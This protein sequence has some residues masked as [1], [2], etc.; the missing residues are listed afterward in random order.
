MKNT[1]RFR[2]YTPRPGFTLIELLVVIAIIALLIGILLPALSAARES[3]RNVVCKSSLRTMGQLNLIYANSNN[4]TYATPVTVGARYTGRV[5]DPEQGGLVSGSDVLEGNSSAVTPTSTQDWISPIMGDSVNLSTNRAERTRQIFNEFGCASARVFNDIIYDGSSPSD[6]DEFEALIID[7][8]RQVSY[9]MPTGFAHLSRDAEAY[10]QGF[11]EEVPGQIPLPAAVNGMMSHPSS[12]QQPMGFRHKISRVGTSPSSKVMVSDA[13][14]YWDGTVLD[15]DPATNPRWYG[16][17]TAS[18]PQYDG[19][20]SMGRNPGGLREGDDT[21]L[22]LTFRH[23]GEINTAR[24]DGSVGQLNQTE[25][26]T[27]PRPWWPTG[28]RWNE[29]SPTPESELFMED[30][31]DGRID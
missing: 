17:F 16:S 25:T 7:G 14:R 27:D 22:Q 6:F 21:N 28:T 29:Q 2:T 24:F 8:I 3:A 20:R 23:G 4:E 1:H 13:T 12:P 9:L 5:V 10:I 30:D 26:W 18:S 31:V 15:F 19:S 11:A